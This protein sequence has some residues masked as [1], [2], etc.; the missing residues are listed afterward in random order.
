MKRIA[1]A[2]IENSCRS[3][4]SEALAKL[5]YGD[6]DF[7]FVSFGTSPAAQVDPGAVEALQEE[8]IEWRGTCKA[9]EQIEKPDILV[10]MGCGMTCPYVPGARVFDWEL[11]DPKGK[12]RQAY[13]RTIQLIKKK[14]ND[15]MSDLSNATEKESVTDLRL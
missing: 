1:F 3:Q 11:E 12:D 15:L 4:M 2:C 14:L 6:Q 7:E 9:M 5:L 10:T 13:Q 8:G